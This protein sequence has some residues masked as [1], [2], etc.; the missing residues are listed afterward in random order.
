[1]TCDTCILCADRLP[2][3]YNIAGA[4]E[5]VGLSVTTIN[6]A[7]KSGELPKR[8]YGSRVIILATDLLDWVMNFPVEQVH[9]DD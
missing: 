3:S 6:A 2:I 5:A 4:A 8:K 9:E 1:M 7:L